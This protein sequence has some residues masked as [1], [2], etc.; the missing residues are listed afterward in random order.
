MEK[1]FKAQIR[2]ID[3]VKKYFT[4]CKLAGIDVSLSP[5]CFMTTWAQSPGYFKL[6]HLT[7]S[8][9]FSF[10]IYLIK[11]LFSISFHHDL[12]CKQTMKKKEINNLIISYCREKNFKRDGSFFDDHFNI[13]SKSINSFWLLISLDNFEPLNLNSNIFVIKKKKKNSFNILY[14][15]NCVI[16][17]ILS[18]FLNPR[19]LSHKISNMYVYT[20][21]IRKIFYRLFKNTKIKNLILNY[22]GIPFQHGIVQEVK[23][24][25]HKTKV[26]CYLH[27][28]GWPLQLD[29][30]YRL[31]LI[32]KLIVSGKD[33]KNVLKNFLK[34][35]SKKI[36]VIPSLRFHKTSI[37][38]YGGFVFVPYEITSFKK[39][40]DRFDFFLNK[41]ANKSI[42]NLKL[43]I[44]PLNK[45]SKKHKK[46]V[47][48]IK[49]KITKH[50]QKFSKKLKKNCSVIFG[51][52]TGVSI[53]TLEYG[54]KI[55][56]IPDNETTDVFSNKIW[57]NINVKKNITGVYEYCVKKRGQ[58]FKEISTKNNFEKYLLPLTSAH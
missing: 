44:H 36:S 55:Y 13:S 20:N 9:N 10:I 17:K 5:K 39:Y 45:N 19:K 3:L 58:M 31:H 43:R 23:K 42:N 52:A 49:R 41:S 2:L 50:K 4:S 27:C 51:S 37:K 21:E 28:A 11:D 32:D 14:L 34:W 15:I 24:I 6:K 53:Q 29:L 12:F 56:H 18:N 16:G 33:Q 54:V 1:H 7:A 8:S 46:F 22:E 30:M 47:N 48:E 40:L 25:N 26:F 38:N 57:P 35:P